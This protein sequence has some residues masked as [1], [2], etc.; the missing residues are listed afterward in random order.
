M[1]DADGSPLRRVEGLPIS[2]SKIAE[3]LHEHEET[4]SV[5]PKLDVPTAASPGFLM[6]DSRFPHL[7]SA[8][9]LPPLEM[10][11]TKFAF[12]QF[13]ISSALQVQH[14]LQTFHR[15]SG[16]LT[17]RPSPGLRVRSL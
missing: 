12:F 15:T 4:F 1:A 5:K 17:F 3:T 16:P 9:S 14:A 2:N 10:I 13:S 7:N 8:S 11:A 6:F